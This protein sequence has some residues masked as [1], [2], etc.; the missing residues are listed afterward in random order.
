M[1]L[2]V[3]VTRASPVLF[4]SVHPRITRSRIKSCCMSELPH[5]FGLDFSGAGA[6]LLV[7]LL[8]GFLLAWLW[9]ALRASRIEA[10]AEAKIAG[11]ESLLNASRSE[12]Q[13]D[14]SRLLGDHRNFEQALAEA[15]RRAAQ[16]AHEVARLKAETERLAKAELASRNDLLAADGEMAKLRNSLQWAETQAKTVAQER[17]GLQQ[18]LQAVANERQSLAAERQHFSAELASARTACELK[19]AEIARLINQVQSHEQRASALEQEKLGLASGLKGQKDAEIANLQTEIET[20]QAA[21]GKER[22]DAAGQLLML[23]AAQARFDQAWKD[24]TYM[25]NLA[26][27]QTSEIERLRG[28]VTRFEGDVAGKETSLA[29]LAEHNATLMAKLAGRGGGAAHARNRIAYFRRQGTNGTSADAHAHAKGAGK[30]SFAHRRAGAK[31]L[32]RGKAYKLGKAFAAAGRAARGKEAGLAAAPAN[33]NRLAGRRIAMAEVAS[34]RAKVAELAADAENYRR[35]R[36]AVHV[37][38]RIAGEEA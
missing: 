19:D 4:R 34:L 1:R 26:Y 3:R 6:W 36:E 22:T 37:A 9:R 21:L 13:A 29:R 7:G 20:V 31:M 33:N 28:V 25:R 32:P 12:H 10:R 23:T 30:L 24:L 15:E 38:N 2:F 11:I 5:Y 8:A 16:G 17:L 14:V 35:L 27:W 18:Q